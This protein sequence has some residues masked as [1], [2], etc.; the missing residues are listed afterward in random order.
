MADFIYFY[1]DVLRLK[2]AS[3]VEQLEVWFWK[4]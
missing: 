4:N 1:E 2:L 3:V